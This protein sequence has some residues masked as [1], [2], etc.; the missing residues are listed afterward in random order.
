MKKEYKRCPGCRKDRHITAFEG[1]R[2]IVCTKGLQIPNYKK[3][4]YD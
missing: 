4:I 2:C 1:E 3:R